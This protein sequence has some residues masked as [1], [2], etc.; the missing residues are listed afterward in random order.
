MNTG[1]K[2]IQ[3]KKDMEKAGFR[4]RH[5]DRNTYNGPAVFVPEEKLQDVIRA[6]ELRLRW[7]TLITSY[8]IYLEKEG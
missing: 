2:Y 5:W 6:T 7:D 3:F 8:V 1:D 4:V